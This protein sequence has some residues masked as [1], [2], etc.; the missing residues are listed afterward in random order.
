MKLQVI[1]VATIALLL[2]ADAGLI[3]PPPGTANELTKPAPETDP[4]IINPLPGTGGDLIKP[5]PGNGG[6]LIIP[7]PDTVTVKE[8][9]GLI[10]YFQVFN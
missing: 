1:L 6:E 9:P 8:L 10:V 5:L 4:E 3:K 2:Q 7:L